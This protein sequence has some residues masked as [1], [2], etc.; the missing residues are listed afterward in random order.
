M[1][2]Q[3]CDNK[4]NFTSNPLHNV[5]LKKI[6]NGTQNGFVNAIFSELNPR[7]LKGDVATIKKIQNDWSNAGWLLEDFC[8]GFDSGSSPSCKYYAIEQP[9][10]RLLKDKI[11]GLIQVAQFPV[12][13]APLQ[14]KLELVKLITKPQF[15][16]KNR[17]REITGIGEVMLAEVFNIARN[18]KAK[19]VDFSPYDKGF[20][21]NTF[22]EAGM[23]L[24][25]PI[26]TGKY[27]IKKSF[28]DKYLKYCENKYGF[29]F[30]SIDKR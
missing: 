18:T 12:K 11:I 7:D 17:F 13:N 24:L 5:K 28:F 20:Y 25:K 8:E 15:S 2:I 29:K 1:K 14:T 30:P 27:H 4:V 21:F 22:K 6:T 19:F 3:N 10:G 23:N 9:E 16:S 26:E